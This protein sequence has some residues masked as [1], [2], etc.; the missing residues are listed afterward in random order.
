MFN[1][2]R[3][4]LLVLKE[5]PLVKTKNFPPATY[6]GGIPPQPLTLFGKPWCYKSPDIKE[7]QEVSG[8]PS[9]L[10]PPQLQTA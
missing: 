3:M 10:A 7:C 5:I 2:E 9:N 8:P 1:M 6:L 4:L